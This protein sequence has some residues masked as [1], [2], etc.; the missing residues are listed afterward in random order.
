VCVCVSAPA[1]H[2]PTVETRANATENMQPMQ[3]TNAAVA[4]D[5]AVARSTAG[6]PANSP[7]VRDSPPK[8]HVVGV[9]GVAAIFEKS[10]T[11]TRPPL[12]PPNVKPA[13]IT[14]GSSYSKGAEGEGGE[15]A[16]LDASVHRD[17]Q[18]VESWDVP[19][20][21]CNP[22]IVPHFFCLPLS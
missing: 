13:H 7:Q 11:P 20:E 19:G 3:V 15:R 8:V 5:A 2:L 22:T 6:A 12:P 4:T 18:D 9:R 16:S 10:S 14:T 21:K 17:S 1:R